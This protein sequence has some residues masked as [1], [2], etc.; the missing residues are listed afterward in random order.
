S[1]KRDM[2]GNDAIFNSF[3]AQ[4]PGTLL[5]FG[6]TATGLVTTSTTVT[7][8]EVNGVPKTVDTL[9]LYKCVTNIASNDP[10]FYGYNFTRWIMRFPGSV[11][12]SGSAGIPPICNVAQTHEILIDN[13]N[14][15][16]GVRVFYVAPWDSSYATPTSITGFPQAQPTTL[17][18]PGYYS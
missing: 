12:A 13:P 6:I 10:A 4:N 17:E 18:T 16:L 5:P 2:Y 14:D 9:G 3:L 11:V 8:F 15:P 1:L 7:I